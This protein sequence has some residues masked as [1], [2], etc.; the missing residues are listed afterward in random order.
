MYVQGSGIDKAF[1]L[2]KAAR[3]S[4]CTYMYQGVLGKHLGTPCRQINMCIYV[5]VCVCVCEYMHLMIGTNYTV[6]V[7]NPYMCI[8]VHTSTHP[9]P[10]HT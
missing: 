10:T 3:H 9:P 7:I 8:H 1:K 6:H 2:L 4:L 5:L